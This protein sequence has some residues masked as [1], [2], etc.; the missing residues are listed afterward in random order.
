M[1][2]TQGKSILEMNGEEAHS[3][4]LKPESYFSADLPKYF[5]FKEML[6]E[7]DRIMK[8]P[9]NKLKQC[10]IQ[11]A[12]K[13]ENINYEIFQNKNSKY[14]WRQL[15]IIHPVL[16]VYL[17]N[18]I[19]LPDVWKEIK[20]VFSSNSPKKIIC[21]SIPVESH[22]N[23]EGQK[24]KASRIQQY[25]T[26]FEQ[27]SIKL[28]LEYTH[29]FQSDITDCYGSIYTHSIPWAIHGKSE[30]KKNRGKNDFIG[31]QIDRSLRSMCF[32]QTNGIPQGSVLMDFIAEI[33]LFYAD[34]CLFEKIEEADIR[35]Y[36]ILRYR[37][38]YRIFVNSSQDGARI[39]KL[40]MET[41]MSLGLRLNTEKTKG[42][43]DIISSSVKKDKRAWIEKKQQMENLQKH[44]LLIRQ[45]SLLYPNAG[46]LF[47]GLNS[48]YKKI[49]NIKEDK[50]KYHNVDVLISI[51]VDI[52]HKNP[53]T[54]SN[55]VAILSK[56]IDQKSN[57]SEKREVFGKIHNRF[58]ELPNTNYMEVW[59]QRI[60]LKV[61]GDL[62][63]FN[64]RLCEV[65]HELRSNPR[66]DI[67]VWE[68]DDWVPTQFK[69]AIKACNIID[70]E[71]IES[72][73]PVISSEEF[74]LFP[75]HYDQYSE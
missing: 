45:H 51:V 9:Q 49:C 35:S 50:W 65:I 62:P 19:T 47:R 13:V 15:Q 20:K 1:G 75:K 36:H 64:E 34:K 29:F 46:S 16:Y 17:V 73:K 43:E 59:L 63:Q 56:L 23:S 28:A 42:S 30:A 61:N 2:D 21:K 33:V 48:F 40:L 60:S 41:L 39:L 68:K 6:S 22:S 18:Q 66:G 7:V 31:N 72:M 26:D 12:S 24:D 3:F 5:S 55:C 71:E 38:D 44:L 27:E 58:K 54:Y 14:S 37:D 4:F 8:E 11:K 67:K 10:N 74:D 53:K 70:L 57:D 69:D 32:G 52:A 25:W